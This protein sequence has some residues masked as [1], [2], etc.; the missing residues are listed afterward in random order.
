M[1]LEQLLQFHL[2]MN[3][4][5]N[6]VSLYAFKSNYPFCILLLFVIFIINFTS[7]WDKYTKQFV[8]D[9]EAWLALNKHIYESQGFIYSI[10]V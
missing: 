10:Y 6:I 2:A 9:L 1:K 4:L 8:C 5:S 7:L 3:Q